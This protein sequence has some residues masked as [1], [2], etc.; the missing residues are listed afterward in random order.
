MGLFLPTIFGTEPGRR[1]EFN[2][3]HELL[4]HW[5]DDIVWDIAELIVL[6]TITAP[7]PTVTK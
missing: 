1:R 5:K 3:T 4:V 2:K 7:V 6:K